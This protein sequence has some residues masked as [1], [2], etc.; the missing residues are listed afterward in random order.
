MR[1][2]IKRIFRMGMVFITIMLSLQMVRFAIETF[3]YTPSGNQKVSGNYR[4]YV[5]DECFHPY[6]EENYIGNNVLVHK[7]NGLST[8]PFVFGDRLYLYDIEKESFTFV[9]GAWA[10]FTEIGTLFMT[11][12]NKIY[13]TI[14]V[15]TD[16]S[17]GGNMYC[18][19]LNTK[20]TTKIPYD[21]SYYIREE[22]AVY[23]NKLY[24][25]KED[26]DED[27]EY[28]TK[29]YGIIFVEI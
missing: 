19:D 27:K 1:K 2:R 11:A 23:K 10:P 17:T 22:G 6:S 3:G 5:T 26:I 7:K 28:R 18:T 13:Y 21:I 8:F 29:D 12:E 24:Y 15:W 4:H 25:R 9:A 14:P 20:R 16:G